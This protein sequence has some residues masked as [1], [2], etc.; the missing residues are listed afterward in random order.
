MESFRK[1]R[2]MTTLPDKNDDDDGISADDDSASS[3]SKSSID[4]SQSKGSSGNDETA[5]GSDSLELD[6]AQNESK[7][8]YRSKL[9]VLTV[10]GTAAASFGAATYIFTRD[11]EQGDFEQQVRAT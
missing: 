3:D 10:I 8:V 11:N 6:I 4:R 9:L 2:E 1:G 7:A 5:T